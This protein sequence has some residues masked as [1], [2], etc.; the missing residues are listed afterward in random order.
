[1]RAWPPD[2][3]APDR[4]VVAML[5]PTNTGKTHAALEAMLRHPNGVIGLPL[6]LL[7]REVYDRLTA[8]LGEGAVALCTGE[9]R[10]IP[11]GARYWACTVEAMPTS[12]PFAFAAVDEVQL[13][14]DPGRGHVF[15]DRLLHLRGTAQTWFC[16]SATVAPLLR[17]LVP[18]VEVRSRPRLSQL[19]HVGHVPLK[20]LP[21]RSAIVAFSAARVVELAEK[22]RRKHGGAAVVF[23]ALS[24]RA[25]N[26]QVAMFEAGEVQ[27]LVATDAIG[28]GL[29]L[30]LDAVALAELDKFDGRSTRRLRPDE[31]AQIAGR[32]G[33]FQTDGTFGTTEGAPPIPPEVAAQVETGDLPELRTLLWRPAEPDVS[34]LRALLTS[35][36]APSRHPA[37]RRTDEADD[38]ATLAELAS[39]PEVL[40]RAT[41]PDAVALLWEVCRVPDYRKAGLQ[42]HIA[43]LVDVYV[44]LCD[45]GRLPARLV[46]SRITQLERLDG[47]VE[48]LLD[49]VA[50]IRT[51]TYLAWRPGWVEDGPA[52]AERALAVETLLSDALHTRLA[53][54]FVDR[55]TRVGGGS[56]IAVGADGAVQV[57]GTA[58]GTLRGVSWEGADPPPAVARGLAE[59]VAA[60]VEALV[61]GPPAF[62]VDDDLR[63]TWRGGPIARLV[64]GPH[65]TEPNLRPIR[66]PLLAPG[67][68]L[69]VHRRAEAWLRD[70]LA[71][72]FAPV[73]APDAPRAARGVLYCLERGLGWC[74]NADLAPD[75]LPGEA[76][77]EL[78]RR[79]VRFGVRFTWS[80]PLFSRVRELALLHAATSGAARLGPLPVGPIVARDGLS[81]ALLDSLGYVFAGPVALR[82]DAAERVAAQLRA[83][84]RSGPFATPAP[85][86]SELGSVAVEVV[87]AFGYS[88]GPAGWVRGR[89]R[90]YAAGEHS[91]PRRP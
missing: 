55:R 4:G 81:A 79:G 69:R 46:E 27:Y 84:A 49:R 82:V 33:R 11:P 1:M 76:R 32:A 66:S 16:G 75:E 85:L 64:A 44:R 83:A 35:L 52:L 87:E 42:P 63:V 5:G 58:L 26:A 13:A 71:E 57:G 24:P 59:E 74:E 61:E 67:A 12:R 68:A 29:N 7:A 43:Q 30:S 91:V 78:G 28:M 72:V 73:R 48:T 40:R 47:E 19:R 62:A 34:S 77:R 8:R 2:A 23:G 3:E 9:E 89:G 37:L 51:W 38:E 53:E 22:V 36:R 50:A 70:W 14:A 6:R 10:R 54:R 86:V 21:P 18:E 25:R 20:S 60:R 90:A 15:T 41:T 56:V 45:R 39:H 65:P 31:L 88:R 80:E 17:R